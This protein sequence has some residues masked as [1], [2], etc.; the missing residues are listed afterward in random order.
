LIEAPAWCS[1]S[2]EDHGQKDAA[3]AA[4]RQRPPLTD[5]LDTSP[6]I[7][8]EHGAVTSHSDSAQFIWH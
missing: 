1:P 7:H 5:R 3:G 2:C 8:R 6:L 4:A